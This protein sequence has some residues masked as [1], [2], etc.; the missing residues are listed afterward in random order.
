M[1]QETA[2][3]IIQKEL[4]QI[5]ALISLNSKQG[6]DVKTLA[7]QELEYLKQVALAKKDINECE[8]MSVLLG[9]KYAM[10]NNLT[11]DQNA[12]LVYI[13]T[14]S[15]N[16][17]TQQSP[18]WKKVL[19]ITPSANG[20]IS[21]NR[22]IGRILDV[23]NPVVKKDAQGKVISVEVELLVPSVPNPRWDKREFDESD[24]TRWARASHKENSRG[25]QDADLT[26]L[27]YANPNY[28]SW[29]GGIDPEFARA[30][31]IRHGLKKL[32]TNPNEINVRQIILEPTELKNVVISKSADEEAINEETT[33]Y[34]EVIETVQNTTTGQN[35]TENNINKIN[36]S[37][38]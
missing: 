15:I 33:Q 32:G 8:P 4:P 31:A 18:V 38:L 30:K 14:R 36:S 10:K 21:I 7:L 5:E 12:A 28:T 3:S 26:K 25:K 24:F 27:N 23:K 35:T 34:A 11:L 9:V 19:E 29:K 37:D 20:L 6:T 16:T 2:I 1:T 22:Q 13:K 17:G